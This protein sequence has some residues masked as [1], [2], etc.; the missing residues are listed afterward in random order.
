MPAVTAGLHPMPV[1]PRSPV[2]YR[3]HCRPLRVER[4]A[5]MAEDLL[6]FHVMRQEG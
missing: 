3:H 6:R 4:E 1:E 2:P 5:M